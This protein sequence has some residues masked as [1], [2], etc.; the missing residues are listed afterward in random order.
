MPQRSPS[1]L[2]PLGRCFTSHPHPT[3]TLP[4]GICMDQFCADAPPGG[5]T[6]M[7]SVGRFAE[8]LTPASHHRIH[9]R[10]PV[11]SRTG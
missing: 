8:F 2:F 11:L 4:H 3:L 10:S 9:N 5:P 6:K 7:D 1:N